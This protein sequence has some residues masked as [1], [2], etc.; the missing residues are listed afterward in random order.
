MNSTKTKKY[1]INYICIILGFAL[2]I[3]AIIARHNAIE[4]SSW[5]IVEGKVLSTK[6]VTFPIKLIIEYE[7]SVGGQIYQCNATNFADYSPLHYVMDCISSLPSIGSDSTSDDIGKSR[8]QKIAEVQGSVKNYPP[9]TIVNVYYNPENPKAAL[10]NPGYS[11]FAVIS[12]TLGVISIIFA[13]IFIF[14]NTKK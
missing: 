8:E 6:A 1:I 13:T 3:W 5:P 2:I 9:G 4:T 14:V 11:G 7:Y 10:L 12:I